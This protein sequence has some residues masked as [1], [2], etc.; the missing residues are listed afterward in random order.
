METR[1]DPT[2]W[3]GLWIRAGACLRGDKTVTV[4][5]HSLV[6]GY[7]PGR[8]NVASAVAQRDV[9]LRVEWLAGWLTCC[10]A[11]TL[12]ATP[13]RYTNTNMTT[14]IKPNTQIL[15]YPH[16]QL[17]WQELKTALYPLCSSL[18]PIFFLCLNSN[19]ISHVYSGNGGHRAL[20]GA[21]NRLK[22]WN[23]SVADREWLSC[24]NSSQH[25]YSHHFLP[26]WSTTHL[27]LIILSLA[28]VLTLK[29][30]PPRIDAF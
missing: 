15:M 17:D 14:H 20:L 1:P 23:D 11:G 16:T 26:L 6:P 3:F 9:W 27:Y 24:A 18:G 22:V 21:G 4:I 7:C 12:N 30:E 29:G 28:L 10:W 5:S 8:L 13:P 25:F 2:Y 19:P